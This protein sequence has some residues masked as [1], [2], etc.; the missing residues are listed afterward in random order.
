VERFPKLDIDQ[1]NKLGQTPLIKA[2]IQGKSKCALALLKHGAD[3]QKKD[4]GRGFCAL[5]WSKYVSL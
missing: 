5:E 3:P 1:L 4:Y 2:A